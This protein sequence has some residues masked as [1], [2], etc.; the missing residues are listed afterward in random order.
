MFNYKYALLVEINTTGTCNCRSR[1]T[2]LSDS[3]LLEIVLDA[4]L[5]QISRPNLSV[6]VLVPVLY[7]SRKQYRMAGNVYDQ[8][9]LPRVYSIIKIF[10]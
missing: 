10:S 8:E 4:S 1:A 7:S 2:A 6:V 9:L 5:L 3:R